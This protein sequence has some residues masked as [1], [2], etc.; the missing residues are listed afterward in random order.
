MLGDRQIGDFSVQV[1]RNESAHVI[2]AQIEDLFSESR[3]DDVLLLHFSGHGLKSES[4]ELFFAAAN[5]RPDCSGP[6]SPGPARLAPRT[7]G[8]G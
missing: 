7:T 8:S 6:R 4:G 5:T 3:P 2:Q 1:V